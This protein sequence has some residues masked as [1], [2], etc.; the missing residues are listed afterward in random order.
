MKI[1]SIFAEKLYAC[2]YKEETHNEFERLMYLWT[3]AVYLREYANQNGIEDKRRFVN[4]IRQDA[5]YI[6]NLMATMTQRNQPLESFFK[7]LN[8]LESGVKVLS[9]Q[10]GR[11]YKLRIYAIKIDKDLCVITGGAIKLVFKMSDHPDTQREKDKLETAKAFFKRN[12][13]FDNDS[14]YELLNENDENE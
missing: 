4:E 11:R 7:P 5:E 8:N 13:I 1:V 10:K 6:E 2:Q 12:G 9:L 14:F 3:D